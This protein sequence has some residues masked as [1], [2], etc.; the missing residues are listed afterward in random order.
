MLRSLTQFEIRVIEQALISHFSGA[1]A[2][3]NSSHSII[4]SFINWT[5]NYTPTLQNNVRKKVFSASNGP[6]NNSTIMNQIGMII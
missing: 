2:K 3:L 4:Y 5:S 1:A 6:I